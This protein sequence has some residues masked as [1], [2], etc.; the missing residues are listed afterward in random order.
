MDAA[1]KAPEEA[2]KEALSAMAPGGQAVPVLEALGELLCAQEQSRH[3]RDEDEDSDD[4][5]WVR[6]RRPRRTVRR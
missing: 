2:A 1:A 5:T 3:S 4:L 6:R